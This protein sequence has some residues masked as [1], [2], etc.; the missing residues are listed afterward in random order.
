MSWAVC[1][2]NLPTVLWESHA[3]TWKDQMSSW[4][5]SPQ[6]SLT[7]WAC[8]LGTPSPSLRRCGAEQS[9]LHSAGP[10][11]KGRFGAEWALLILNHYVF[12]G[13]LLHNYWWPD[14]E[15][16]LW[17]PEILFLLF[18]FPL[19]DLAIFFCPVCYFG[20][21]VEVK[22]EETCIWNWSLA[23]SS[24]KTL[25]EPP[26]FLELPLPLIKMKMIMQTSWGHWED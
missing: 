15:H 7:E 12:C 11:P 13:D 25:C 10:H 6:P 19:W 24:H 20:M 22:A 8:L 14:D 5:P 1:L 17:I 23:I 4:G 9:G 21:H 16:F 2:W 26:N 3:A 18:S